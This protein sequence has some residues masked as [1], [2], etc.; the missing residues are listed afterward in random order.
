[1]RN[2]KHHPGSKPGR[3]VL[4]RSRER[5]AAAG[6]LC[7][8][9][10][11]CSSSLAPA[12]GELSADL[13]HPDPRVRI[14]AAIKAVTQKRLELAAELIENLSD[15]DGAVRMFSAVALRKLTGHDFG[16]KAHGTI[17]EREE[18]AASWR[19]WL[20]AE[21]RKARDGVPQPRAS[22]NGGL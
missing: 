1:M 13:R 15:R 19:A 20:A 11:S 21:G 16:Y 5:L 7:L 14:D 4:R 18:A 22:T 8:G 10:V 6:L 2:L 12:T 17:I 9:A 3:K